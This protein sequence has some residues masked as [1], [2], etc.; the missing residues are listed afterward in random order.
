MTD[1]HIESQLVEFDKI[2]FL[3]SESERREQRSGAFGATW[4]PKVCKIMAFM[5]I[6]LGL[7]LLFYTL[8]GLRYWFQVQGMLCLGLRTWGLAFGSSFSVL[9][10]WQ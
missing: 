8:L 10:L 3:G 7:G 6:T 9:T 5:A 1:L 2:M 4:T